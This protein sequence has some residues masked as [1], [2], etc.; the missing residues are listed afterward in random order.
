MHVLQGAQLALLHQGLGPQ[1]PDAVATVALALGLGV[2][3]E[4]AQ[5]ADEVP[6]AALEDVCMALLRC[7]APRCNLLHSECVTMQ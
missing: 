7:L 5:Y 2:Y 4:Q 3:Y 1:V 6:H